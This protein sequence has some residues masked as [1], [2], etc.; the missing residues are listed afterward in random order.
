MK[1]IILLLMMVFVAPLY[2][3]EIVKMN[4]LDFGE[5]V[6]GDKY[7]KLSNIRVYVEGEPGESVKISYPESYTTK[8]GELI[9][10]AREGRIRLSSSGRGRFTLDCKLNLNRG[11]SPGRINEGIPIT[12]SYK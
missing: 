8:A 3:V 2:G 1:K 11:K 12:V 4:H 5:A 9:I 6:R 7:V 10:T